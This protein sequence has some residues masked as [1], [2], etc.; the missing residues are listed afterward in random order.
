MKKVKTTGDTGLQIIGIEDKVIFEI[1]SEE[2][3]VRDKWVIAINELLQSWVD[4]PESK[5][6]S[7]ISAS[8]TSNKGEY[9]RKREEEIKAREKANNER[10]AKYAAGGMTYTA[11]IMAERGG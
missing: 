10:K 11:Q 1:K 6:K 3:A 4:N 2:A 8:G 7:S 9:F 5:P